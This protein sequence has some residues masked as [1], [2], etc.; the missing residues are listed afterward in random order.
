MTE[1]VSLHNHSTLSTG[2]GYG[3]PDQVMKI[4]EKVGYKAFGIT[5]H[6]GVF[7]LPFF[8]DLGKKTKIKPIM[9]CEV[10]TV[11]DINNNQRS[12]NHLTILANSLVGYKN[13]MKLVTLSNTKEYF[14]YKPS[15]DLN[16]IEQ[17]KEGLTILSG[18]VSSQLSQFILE[19]NLDEAVKYAKHM[20]ESFGEKFYLELMP[21][22]LDTVRKTSPVI[23][24]LSKRLNIPIVMTN[25]V[26][27][28]VK[29]QENIWRIL[30]AISRRMLVKDIEPMLDSCYYMNDDEIFA[31]AKKIL[32][33]YFEDKELYD[34]ITI[35]Q[36]IAADCDNIDIPR[37][38]N[39]KSGY[40]NPIAEVKRRAYAGMDKY[41]VRNPAYIQRTE[42]EL[43]LID[44]KGFSDYFI[45]V[46]DTINWAKANDIMVGDSRG[47]SGCSLVCYLMGV[48]GVDPMKYDLVMERFLSED[49]VDP[50]DIDT[51][52]DRSK[53]SLVIQHLNEQFGADKVAHLATFGRWKGRNS[54][55]EIGK[56]FGIPPDKVATVQ[57]MLVSRGGADARAS[58][59]IEDTFTEFKAARQIAEEYPELLNA[60]LLEQ[61]VKYIGV[62]A[63]GMVVSSMPLLENTALLEKTDENGEKVNTASLNGDS[64]HILGILKIDALGLRNLTMIKNMLDEVGMKPDDLQHIDLEDKDV[65]HYIEEDTKGV[66]QFGAKA[67]A[68]IA[69]QVGVDNF[70]DVVAN[71]AL[72][73]PGPLHCIWEGTKV[74]D[75]DHDEIV[76]IKEAYDR[77]ITKTVGL[78]PNGNIDTADVIRVEYTGRKKVFGIKV[79]MSNGRV[80]YASD[81]HRFMLSSGTWKQLKDLAIG[82]KILYS[83]RSSWN[84]GLSGEELKKHY[85]ITPGIKKGSKFTNSGQF[86]KG[87]KPWNYGIEWPEMGVIR[88]KQWADGI[89]DNVETGIVK[90]IKERPDLVKQWALKGSQAAT[91]KYNNLSDEEKAKFL[92]S[93]IM[94]GTEHGLGKKQHANDGDYCQ[95]NCE[96]EA[97]DWLSAHDVKHAC[98][99]IIK[100]TFK[101]F[102]DFL[103]DGIYIEIDGMGR[104]DGYWRDKY[105]ERHNFVVVD[106]YK[107]IG[108]QLEW[109]LTPKNHNFVSISEAEIANIWD[110]GEV[111]TYDMEIGVI[112]NYIAN[113]FVVHNTGNTQQYSNHKK[114]GTRK[115][116]A[117][118]VMNDIT[119]STYGL[120]VFQEQVLRIMKEIG[121]FNY[122]QVAAI[123][124]AMSRSLGDEFFNKYRQIFVDGSTKKHGITP[125]YANEMFDYTSTFGCLSGDTKIKLSID[126]C[127]ASHEID[128]SELCREWEDGE[129]K[130]NKIFS[131]DSNG[132]VVINE[133][134]NVMYSGTKQVYKISTVD[135]TEICATED[136]RFYTTNAW[137]KLK[138]LSLDDTLFIVMNDNTV[139]LSKICSIVSMGIVR[140]YDVSVKSP[141]NS[142]IAN[143]FVVHNSWG[144]NK[145][146]AVAYALLAYYT[147]YFKAKH[148]QLFYKTMCNYAEDEVEMKSL[149]REYL[150]KGMGKILPPKIGLSKLN[151]EVEGN[152][153][154]AG[155]A[156]ILPTACAEE[157]LSLY[158]IKDAADLLARA[159][160]RK[161]NSAR[162][163][164]IEEKKLFDYNTN[165]DVFGLYDFAERMSYVP[166]RTHKIGDLG[167]SFDSRHAIIAGVLA[168]QIN[169]KSIEELRQTSKIQDW[170]QRFNEAA[171]DAW[172]I[173]D[174]Q[175]ESE[176]PIHVHFKNYL[177]PKYKDMLWSKKIGEDILIVK[178]VLPG[179]T[180]YMIAQEAWE[181]NDNKLKNALCYKCPLIQNAFINDD[182][183]ITSKLAFIGEGPGNE[184]EIQ[185]KPFVGKAGL[186]LMQIF[187]ELGIERN[188]V[189]IDNTVRCHPIDETGHNR[190]PYPEEI[191]CCHEALIKRIKLVPNRIVVA[192]GATA[193]QA[194]TGRSEGITKVLGLK[195]DCDGF[196]VIP[197]YHPAAALHQNNEY[198]TEIIKK[199][200]LYAKEMAGI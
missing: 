49:R 143:G 15:L 88:T 77:K 43:D 18:C 81:E 155:L 46:N 178:G 183:D 47:S 87:Q 84:E 10:R 171:G 145:A 45:V 13:L 104:D 37:A 184:E 157:I 92:A 80:I 1:W 136:H 161:V 187:S 132:K 103:V 17:H 22:D 67:T 107:N 189:W 119:Q 162:W 165:I 181:W 121:D 9:G 100:G 111:D 118:D 174:I 159:Q 19:D 137:K 128:I 78:Y 23:R 147:A 60:T 65:L 154:R 172:C 140:T 152:D 64:S 166:E 112:H 41:G 97:D 151:W 54:L 114:N 40:D 42:M 8:W 120:I 68:S 76:T 186:K 89:Y 175:D 148:P 129:F 176:Q 169:L 50:P 38:S 2:D 196:T 35:T 14:Y 31:Q 142:F 27:Y 20:K 131:L 197:T 158:P 190:K 28:M 91:N 135:N 194:I 110:A 146:H 170:R 164:T 108:K 48:T 185:K 106:A 150:E 51:D 63:S 168:A 26:H 198:I 69:K 53:R 127:D 156:T 82:D 109:L 5:D 138:Q 57:N 44:R 139:K 25:D 117:L 21:H 90:Y 133:I 83:N 7:A 33:D 105:G 115:I 29:G 95:S 73:R 167:Y 173:C 199:N 125:E 130:N 177:Y 191:E 134:V 113:G 74:Y 71:I 122:E 30:T 61:Q 86:I 193:Y 62:H 195:I 179:N 58:F 39:V 56:A 72:P 94:A 70:N 55:A 75:G 182:G 11:P 192:L 116:W 79:K 124:N 102:A 85:S 96:R 153:L 99:P 36:K 52:Y 149:L 126:G 16:T 188:K 180:N 66:F 123:R 24:A 98:H 32:G 93:F 160:R 141:N 59:C 4:I 34:A 3:N 6:D 101:R 144:F 12:K 200:I 163:K